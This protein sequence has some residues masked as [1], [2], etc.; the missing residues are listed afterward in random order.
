MAMANAEILNILSASPIDHPRKAVQAF[1][2]SNK[3]YA[4]FS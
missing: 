4:L 2:V 3:S 1:K